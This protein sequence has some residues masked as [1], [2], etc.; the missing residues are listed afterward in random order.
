LTV[1]RKTNVLTNKSTLENLYSFKQFPTY[2]GCT[3][4]DQKKDSLLDLSVDICKETG[5]LQLKYLAALDQVYLYPH[6][7]AIGPTWQEHN[8]KF[9]KFIEKS[10]PKQILEIGGGSGKLA[11]EYVNTHA[12]MDWTILDPNPLFEKNNQIHSKKE[13]FSSKLDFGHTFETIIHSHVLEHQSSPEVFFSDISKLLTVNGLHIFSFPNLHEWLSRKYLNCLN[14]EHTI[15]LTEDYVDVSLK[16]TGFEIIK[17]IKFRDDHSIFYLTKFSGK[18]QDINYPNLYE[19][20]KKLYLEYIQHYSEFIKN[21][22]FKLK[23]SS[24]KIYLFG[25]HIFSQYLLA[26]GLDQTK[27][28]GILD[29]SKLKIG[30]RLY[31][32]NLQVFHPEIIENENAGIILKVGSYRDEIIQQL[33][34]INPNVTIFE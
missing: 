6:N 4:T 31:G 21:L 26:F 8:K 23:H 30:K 17:K 14:F 1:L 10:L 18:K 28:F 25:A 2:V 16:R 32:T 9:I 12:N 7:D 3:T 27:L 33:K 20:N 22:N 34:K 29:N 5:I 13:Y 15:F 11:L 24:Q 19:K